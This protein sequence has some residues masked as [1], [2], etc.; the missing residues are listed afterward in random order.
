M[1]RSKWLKKDRAESFEKSFKNEDNMVDRFINKLR[2]NKSIAI[3]IESEDEED[4][5]VQKRSNSQQQN[6]QRNYG[7][8]G[9]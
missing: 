9:Y 3:E 1:D 6:K 4:D 8:G 7:R 2:G 5:S